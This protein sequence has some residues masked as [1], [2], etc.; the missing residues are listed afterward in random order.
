MNIALFGFGSVG[1]SFTRLLEKQKA[2]YPFRIVAVHTAHHGT[3]FDL[4]GITEATPFGPA[5]S[6]AEE[7]LDKANAEVVVEITSLSPHDGQPAIGHIR[8]AFARGI[9]VITANKGPIAHAYREL[10]NEAAFR[11]LHFRYESTVMDG[12]P[13]FNMV[14]HNLP[15]INIHGFSAVFN[16]TT[17]VVLQKMREG[18]SQA[19]GIAAAQELG[20]AE[21][22]ASFDIDGWDS[23]AKTAALANV[24]MDAG[25][26]PLNVDRSGI[27]HLTPQELASI[28][29]TDKVVALV[30]RAWRTDKDIQ[31]RVQAEALDRNDPL[32]RLQGTSNLLQLDT[33]HMGTLGILE[34]NP[35]VEQTAYGLF[36]DLVDVA[37]SI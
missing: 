34:F 28:E 26:T 18:G 27:G 10:R 3:A 4:A 1:R 33:D 35:T 22:D 15:G 2:V 37:K 23:A 30:A 19:E 36:T 13:V 6:S 14:R 29:G 11:Q 17:Q 12:T 25:M 16:S 9:H 21:T 20:I 32:A 8:A 7:F 24:L 5:V 31:L